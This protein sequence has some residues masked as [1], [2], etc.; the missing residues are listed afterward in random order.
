MT[1]PPLPFLVAPGPG[2][3]AIAGLKGWHPA[4]RLCYHYPALADTGKQSLHCPDLLIG[5]FGIVNMINSVEA[6]EIDDR[7]KRKIFGRMRGS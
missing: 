3:T 6:M 5:E 7:E 1:G 2:K 4:C